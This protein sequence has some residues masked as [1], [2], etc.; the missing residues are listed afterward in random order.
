MS[1]LS[2]EDYLAILWGKPGNVANISGFPRQSIIKQPLSSRFLPPLLDAIATLC[3]SKAQNETFAVSL[4][5]QLD[6]PFPAAT[7]AGTPSR[8]G[9]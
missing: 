6:G 4:A 3:V 1:S 8:R 2:P 9:D 7:A 5:A